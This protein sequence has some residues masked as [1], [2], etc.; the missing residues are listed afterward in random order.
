M[1]KNTKQIFFLQLIYGNGCN[2]LAVVSSKV[3]KNMNI[4]NLKNISPYQDNHYQFF[5]FLNTSARCSVSK[6]VIIKN[7]AITKTVFPMSTINSIKT[8]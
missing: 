5:F 2:T 4:V 1:W 6:I 7:G 3:P 8:Q